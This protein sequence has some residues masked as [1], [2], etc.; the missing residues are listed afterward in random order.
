M[1][2]LVSPRWEGAGLVQVSILY[3]RCRVTVLLEP[4]SFPNTAFVS[5]LYWRCRLVCLLHR[6]RPHDVAGFN[7][8]LEMR[9]QKAGAQPPR[10]QL[11]FNSLLE[12]QRGD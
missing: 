6:R 5:I 4:F 9:E 11:C 1:C 10:F 12:M 2:Q 7:S 8:L 3:W